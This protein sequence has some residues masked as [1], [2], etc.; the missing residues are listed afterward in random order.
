MV[1][2][3]EKF[4]SLP[5]EKRER[6]LQAGYRVF[7]H[8]AYHSAPMNEAAL[9]AGVSKSLLF[10]YFRN[11]KEFYLYLW[12]HIAENSVSIMNGY[13][14]YE[15]KDLFEGMMLGL[16][17]KMDLMRSN[18]EMALFTLKAFFET[19]PEIQSSIQNLSTE[20]FSGRGLNMILNLDP[21][22]FREGTNIPLMIREMFLASEGYLWEAVMRNEVDFEKMEQDFEQMIQF[23]K[24]TW[25]NQTE[26]DGADRTDETDKGKIMK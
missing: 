2:V 21:G 22:Q 11:K 20:Y 24:Q 23:W 13:G 1:L 15:Q 18:P 5:E 12:N 4:F 3:N 14:C 9:E 10:H 7:A 25:G 26:T 8:N 16:K 19:D 17:A 6:I